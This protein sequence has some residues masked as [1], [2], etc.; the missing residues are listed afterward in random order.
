MLISPRPQVPRRELAKKRKLDKTTLSTL[1][2]Q[3]RR[4]YKIPKVQ[5]KVRSTAQP[6]CSKNGPSNQAPIGRPPAE[7][8]YPIPGQST[9]MTTWPGRK[10][11]VAHSTT[12]ADLVSSIIDSS[13]NVDEGRYDTSQL[14]RSR[15]RLAEPVPDQPQRLT[16][17]APNVGSKTRVSTGKSVRFQDKPQ[18]RYIEKRQPKNAELQRFQFNGTTSNARVPSIMSDLSVDLHGVIY[19]ICTWNPRWFQEQAKFGRDKPPPVCGVREVNI[20]KHNFSGYSDYKDTFYPLLLHELWARVNKQMEDRQT[21]KFTPFPVCLDSVASAHNNGQLITL[22]CYRNIA[23]NE[24]RKDGFPKMGDLVFVNLKLPS[25]SGEETLS[26]IKRRTKVVY[27]YICSWKKDRS[28]GLCSGKVVRFEVQV[29]KLDHINFRS[30]STMSLRVVSYIRSDLRAMEALIALPHMPLY[31]EVLKPSLHR[32]LLPCIAASEVLGPINLNPCQKQAVLAVTKVVL[33]RPREPNIN[34]MQGPPGTGKSR[35]IV[36]LVIELLLHC[37]SKCNEEKP[38]ILVCAPSNAAVDELASR[39]YNLISS[40]EKIEG[41]P[42]FCVV[43]VGQ[44]PAM[45]SEAAKISLDT[46]VRHRL[47]KDTSCVKQDIEIERQLI[48]A[49]Q[50]MYS[51]QADKYKQKGDNV[52]LDDMVI[53]EQECVRKMADLDQHIKSGQF[54]DADR[55]SREPELRRSILLE[56]DVIATTMTSCMTMPLKGLFSGREKRAHFTCCIVDEASQCIEPECLIPLTL[57][58]T[59]LFLVGD[60][61]QL[62]ATVLSTMA[63]NYGLDQSLFDRLYSYYQKENCQ[64]CHFLNIQYRMHPDIAKFPNETFYNG[65]LRTGSGVERTSPFA[66]YSLLNVMHGWETQKNGEICNAME[67]KCVA[68]L[69]HAIYNT[70]VR[71]KMSMGIIT[72]YRKQRDQIIGLLKER[73]SESRQQKEFFARVSVNTVDSYQGQEKD[74]ILLS[75]V[76]AQNNFSGQVGFLSSPKRLNVA[77]TRAKYSLI[78]CGN[79]TYL[80]ENSLWKSLVEDGYARKVVRNFS[81]SDLYDPSRLKKLVLRQ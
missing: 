19:D 62:P 69:S 72:P 70:L 29:R 12:R 41:K 78:I 26:Q 17:S 74:V 51:V 59:K 1:G 58:M 2:Q 14:G 28:H 18:M 46:Y 66:P 32:C 36:A 77:L 80:R 5:E 34:F 54:Q 57:E 10:K 33:E 21:S 11:K 25:E 68:F 73:L 40:M 61:N 43:R 39:L 4:K 48:E 22:S 13:S 55:Q 65:R 37:K 47:E 38:K 67:A 79:M 8:I 49:E 50:R 52:K 9:V 81:P 15:L 30:F 44:T 64:P 20:V 63:R 45:N 60:P 75:C 42:P 16:I 27:G 23:C 7:D 6:S 56:A 35:V 31:S 24:D 3:D 71:E 53:K 76:R